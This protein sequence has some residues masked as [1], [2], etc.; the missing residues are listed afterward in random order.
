MGQ[1]VRCRCDNVEV[2]AI[3]N[4]GSCKE[5]KAMHLTRS[6]VF[7][8]VKHQLRVHAIHIPVV[9]NQS[10]DALLIKISILPI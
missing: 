4:L 1:S 10:A 3:I 6:A 9:K 2:V 5:N 8:M 7:F